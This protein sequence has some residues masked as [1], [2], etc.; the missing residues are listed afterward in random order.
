[1]FVDSN[2]KVLAGLRMRNWMLRGLRCNKS[3]R[4]LLS[5]CKQKGTRAKGKGL[6]YAPRLPLFSPN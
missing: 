1:M 6:S 2:S 5:P 4:R 3:A